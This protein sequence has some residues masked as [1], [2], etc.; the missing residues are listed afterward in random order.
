MIVPRSTDPEARAAT[1]DRLLRVA[2]S[3]FGQVGFEQANINTIAERAGLGKGT[4]YLYFPSKHDLFLALLRAISQRQIAAVRAALGSGKLQQQLEALVS[5]IARC[6]LE[7]PDGFHVYMS[8]LYGV[9]RAF[10]AEAVRLL[11]EY[12]ALLGAALAKQ[13]PYR[14]ME[15][16]NLE[17]YALW[18]FS[19]S[20]SFVLAA[21]ALGYSDQQ[22]AALMPTL[23]HL[24]LKGLA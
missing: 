4:I 17:A 22:L 6:A 15:P 12:L 24:L 11:Q 13:V 16:A 21:R 10:Q 1:Y 9:N 14:K 18:L 20:E 7:D 19:A 2:A 5:A 8:A 3:E 23:A